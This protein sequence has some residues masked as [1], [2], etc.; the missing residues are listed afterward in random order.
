M[1]VN[2]ALTV[3]N[4]SMMVVNG[5]V[6]VVNGSMMVLNGAL[7]VVNKPMTV[8]QGP[9]NGLVQDVACLSAS[10]HLETGMHAL[11]SGKDALP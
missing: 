1:V 10:H 6:T 11:E 3:I 2:G 8:L 9:E 4:G 5:A 7:T